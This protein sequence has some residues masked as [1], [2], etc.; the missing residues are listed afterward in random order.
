MQVEL[1][2][3][4][5]RELGLEVGEVEGRLEFDFPMERVGLDY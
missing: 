1:L 4:G 2:A 3:G 5:G